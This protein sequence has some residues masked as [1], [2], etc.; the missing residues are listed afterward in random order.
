MV[1]LAVPAAAL[2]LL[3]VVPQSSAGESCTEL[4]QNR[5][6]VCHYITRVC[7]RVKKDRTRSSWFGG[8]AGSWKRIIKNMVR[9]GAKLDSDEEKQLVECL[10]TPAPEVSDICGLEK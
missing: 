9:Q 3:A 7:D 5:C 8:T 1:M 10:S 2:W 4:L 6:E